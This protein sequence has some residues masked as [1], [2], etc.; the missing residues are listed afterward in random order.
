[1]MMI[2]LISAVINIMYTL[3]YLDQN[4]GILDGFYSLQAGCTH[5]VTRYLIQSETDPLYFE[6]R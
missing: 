2:I 1:M 6:Y 5:L 4:I 3:S